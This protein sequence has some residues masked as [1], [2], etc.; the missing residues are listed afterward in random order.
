M[1]K[2][3]EQEIEKERKNNKLLWSDNKKLKDMEL[4]LRDEAEEQVRNLERA[5]T[6]EL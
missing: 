6:Q 5:K 3:K 1:I 2:L 4:K